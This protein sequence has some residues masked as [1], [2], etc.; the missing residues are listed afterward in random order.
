M[1]EGSSGQST[2]QWETQSVDP[3]NGSETQ[4]TPAGASSGESPVNTIAIQHEP[5]ANALASLPV[6]DTFPGLLKRL[7]RKFAGLMGPHHGDDVADA[8]V[9]TRIE[10]VLGYDVKARTVSQTPYTSRNKPGWML[11]LVSK[12]DMKFTDTARAS[13]GELSQLTEAEVMDM[14]HHRIYWVFAVRKDLTREFRSYSRDEIADMRDQGVRIDT[15]ETARL[16]IWSAKDDKALTLIVSTDDGSII[17][18]LNAIGGA[19]SHDWSDRITPERI[20]AV[21][22]LYM[23]HVT[24][25]A[26]RGQYRLKMSWVDQTMSVSAKEIPGIIVQMND[27]PLS[28][29]AVEAVKAM[30]RERAKGCFDIRVRFVNKKD[31]SLL[32]VEY[33]VEFD[34]DDIEVYEAEEASA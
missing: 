15:F 26:Q 2:N 30:A 8:P 31:K 5:H 13:L 22:D 6:S 33:A 1:R 17:T 21:R 11:R 10:P 20:Q 28:G 24:P 16:L 9:I 25:A 3:K 12:L 23:D 34:G 7:F 14:L 32:P 19:G 29:E 27:F 18:V 4:A